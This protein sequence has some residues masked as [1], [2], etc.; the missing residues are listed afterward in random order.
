MSDFFAAGLVSPAV[1]LHYGGTALIPAGNGTD[2]RPVYLPGRPRVRAPVLALRRGQRPVHGCRRHGRGQAS[3]VTLEPCGVSAKTVWIVDSLRTRSRHGYVP[4]IN[5]SDTNFSHPFVMTYPGNG[6][7]TD[8][9]RPQ[10]YVTNLTGSPGCYRHAV[11]AP[12]TPTSSSV[13][14]SASSPV[15]R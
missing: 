1:A 6:Y 12:S 3:K 10:L 2:S 4:L 15:R 13:P 14:T 7:P 9:P 11:R 8:K 5:G